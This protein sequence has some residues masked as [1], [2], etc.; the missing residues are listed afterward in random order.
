MGVYLD[1]LGNACY[2]S[3]L[4]CVWLDCTL[5]DIICNLYLHTTFLCLLSAKP[6]IIVPRIAPCSL[7]LL[8][9]WKS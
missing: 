8:C 4:C 3:V 6:V 7:N 9:V 5:Y 2:D 1:D